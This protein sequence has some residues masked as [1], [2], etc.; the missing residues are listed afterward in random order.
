MACE[1][2]RWT[3]QL[4]LRLQ[5]RLSMNNLFDK[6]GQLKPEVTFRQVRRYLPGNLGRFKWL[7]NCL[8]GIWRYQATATAKFDDFA[9][10]VGPASSNNMQLP[11]STF[12]YR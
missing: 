2:G 1:M 10:E 9:S 3:P 4:Q 8:R 6:R 12:V 7:R 5:D 11:F